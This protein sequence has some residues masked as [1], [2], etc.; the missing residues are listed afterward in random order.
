ME[1]LFAW[2]IT[3][4]L[5]IDA[6][7]VS[8]TLG[9]RKHINPRD[10]LRIALVFAAIES[11]MPISGIIIGKALGHYFAGALTAI[12]ALLLIG[13]A[14]YLVL[15]DRDQDESEAF[16]RPLAGWALITVAIG[17]GLDELAVG[18]T[19]GLIQ[20]PIVF[21]TMMIAAQS[22]VFSII[23]VTFGAKFKRYLGEWAEKASGILLALVGVWMLIEM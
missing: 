14:I 18:F 16:E 21:M 8:A 13:V 6:F 19:A 15:F 22:F 2:V 10:K 23:G 11:L 12:G 3:L 7:I 9:L 4:S 20:L 17:I 1:T 5:G